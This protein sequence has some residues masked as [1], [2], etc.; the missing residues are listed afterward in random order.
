MKQILV[1]AAALGVSLIAMAAQAGTAVEAYKSPYCGCC[2]GWVEHMRQAGYEVTVH[3]TDNLNPIKQK[4]GV[5]RDIASCHTAFV[6]GYV[7]EGHV[8]AR[9][10]TR[11]LREH[12]MVAGLAVPRMPVGSPGMDGGTPEPYDVLTFNGSGGTSVFARYR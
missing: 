2:A 11:L 4:H 1:K 8:P 12:P 7:I 10:I 5:T 9:E 3:N 6:G